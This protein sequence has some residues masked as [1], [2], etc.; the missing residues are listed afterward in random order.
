MAWQC[1]SDVR[2]RKSWTVRNQFPI[3]HPGVRS[4]SVLLSF[5][6]LILIHPPGF[7]VFN[8]NPSCPGISERPSLCPV[9]SC[10]IPVSPVSD[11]TSIY[12]VISRV[13]PVWL[14]DYYL[15]LFSFSGFR[16]ILLLYLFFRDLQ[17]ASFL[18]FRVLS[19]LIVIS[20]LVASSVRFCL[21][22]P[23]SAPSSCD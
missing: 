20:I 7:R 22:P 21:L 2:K 9:D 15:H 18:F 12:S 17:P 14:P 23:C 19:C 13:S 10:S 5:N 11:T 16:P 3:R 6:C 4:Q 1:T 8:P